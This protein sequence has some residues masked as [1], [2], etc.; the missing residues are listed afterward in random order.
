MQDG[1]N[2]RETIL[3]LA[4]APVRSAL[5]IIRISGPNTKKIIRQ[6]SQSKEDFTQNPRK[7]IY[8]HFLDRQ[9][10]ILD[11]GLL[12][13]YPKPHSYTGEEVAEFFIHGNPLLLNTIIEEILESS[14]ARLAKAGEFTWQA[15]LN[16]KLDLSQAE[17]VHQ[18]IQARSRWELNAS[19]KNLQGGIKKLCYRLRSDLLHLKA[20]I[21]A[22]ID[23]QEENKNWEKEK[24]ESI[25]KIEEKISK[26]L[27]SSLESESLRSLYQISIV[28]IPNA[29]KSSLFNKILGWERTLVNPIA[30]TT[31]D[32]INEEI[33]LENISIRLIDTAGIHESKN[34][35][36][37]QGIKKSIELIK[38]SQLLLLVI[39]GESSVYSYDEILK[40]IAKDEKKPKILYV[41]NKSDLPSAQEHLSQ[42]PHAIPISC[43]LEKG[44]ST[45]K[46]KIKEIATSQVDFENLF[47]LEVR[48]Q[49]H[50]RQ[51]QKHLYKAKKLIQENAFD[52]IWCIEIDNCIDEIGAIS[53]VIDN[54]EVLGRI[55]SLFCV[56]K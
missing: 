50:L 53:H 26:V 14:L 19:Q 21:E 49:N 17:A 33:Q 9:K 34:D 20:K 54:E 24:I 45:L 4:S 41:V 15:F 37:K 25:E 32:Y 22:H 6:Y 28:G 29:G 55:F 52:E 39:D 12:A 42:L 51:A 23:F 13:Y 8:S 47:L 43:Q 3:A 7:M 38:N 5:G 30:G 10:K 35:I 11:Q 46:E 48:H 44:L 36:E 1:E 2:P 18:V 40:D 31:R 27:Q 16:R 56:G